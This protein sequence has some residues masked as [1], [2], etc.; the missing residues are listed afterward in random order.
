MP[1]TNEKMKLTG[2]T[3]SPRVSETDFKAAADMLRA[4]SGIWSNCAKR[5]ATCGD[6]EIYFQVFIT[7]AVMSQW[8]AVMSQW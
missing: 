5:L 1:L 7:D 8:Y 3:I 6:F 4:T 2:S